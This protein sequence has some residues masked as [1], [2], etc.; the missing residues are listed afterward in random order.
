MDQNT[1][2]ELDQEIVP[3][4]PLSEE[5]NDQTEPAKTKPEN[6]VS[7]IPM[8]YFMV[9]DTPSIT[10]KPL[11]VLTRGKPVEVVKSGKP[12]LKIRHPKLNGKIGYVSATILNDQPRKK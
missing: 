6:W 3:E 1:T 9:R 5:S 8:E 7:V 2:P 10:G 4:A 12:W 11:L